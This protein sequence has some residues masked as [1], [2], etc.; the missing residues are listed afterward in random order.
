VNAMPRKHRRADGA[1]RLGLAGHRS[2]GIT[3]DEADA[4]AGANGRATVND[5]ASDC[6]QALLELTRVLHRENNMK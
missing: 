5:A 6:G 2:D 1:G 4:D 3:D